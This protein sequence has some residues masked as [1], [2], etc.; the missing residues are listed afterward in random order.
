ME[1]TKTG[2]IAPDIIQKY[3]EAKAGYG[4]RR[5]LDGESEEVSHLP[6]SSIRLWVNKESL[7]YPTHW[8]S[9]IELILPI[10]NDYTV[11]IGQQTYSLNPGDI[12]LIPSGQLHSLIAPSEGMRLILLFDITLLNKFNGYSFLMSHLSQPI[13]IN[14]ENC[15][16]IYQE[17]IDLINHMCRDYFNPD[18]LKDMTFYGNLIR[19]LSNYVRFRVSSES[20]H[21]TVTGSKDYQKD[22]MLKFNTVY[23]YI[24]QHLSEDLSLETVA[25]VA[26]FSKYHFSRLFKVYSGYN[27][28]DYVSMQRIRSAESLLLKPDISITE[29]ALL[30]GFSSLT[31]F[32]R[33]FKKIKDCT[34]S[35]YRKLFQY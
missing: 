3:K 33:T 21:I 14:R 31:T 1:S 12:L 15:R 20:S 16:P 19:F 9:D 5:T 18:A 35:E 29:V 25:E 17:M 34:P 32:N 13:L 23:D 24:N 22:L 2:I 7:T 6:G 4:F 30:S 11:V 8:H 10:E 27:F 26:G 28:Y